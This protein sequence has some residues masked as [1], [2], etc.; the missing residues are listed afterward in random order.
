MVLPNQAAVTFAQK[1]EQ[2]L[3]EI[4]PFSTEV[5]RLVKQRVGQDTFRQA[6]LDYWGGACAVT[7]I[8]LPEVLRASHAKPWADCCDDQE[9]LNAFNGFLLTANLDALFD[10]GLITFTD[11]WDLICSSCLGE[12]QRFALHLHAHLKLR[13]IT[14]HY[15]PF[16]LWHRRKIFTE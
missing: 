15:D 8:A 1:V 6:I 5:E 4:N 7:G 13:W 3:A 11:K 14:P 9:R 16:L 2:E 10:R 12:E